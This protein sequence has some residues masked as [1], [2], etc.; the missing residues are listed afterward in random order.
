[1]AE[2]KEE[3]DLYKKKIDA[4]EAEWKQSTEQLV[5]KFESKK[6]SF[7]FILNSKGIRT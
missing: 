1:M 4:K 5:S 2:Q 3:I 7:N 6:R